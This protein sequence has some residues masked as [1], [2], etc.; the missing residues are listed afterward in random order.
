MTVA[1]RIGVMNAGK[2]VQVGPPSEVYEQPK[3]RWIADFI[4]DVNLIEGRVVSSGLGHAVIEAVAGGRMLV[5]YVGPACD[6]RDGVG[7]A[8]AG[9]IAD[10]PQRVR[11]RA[12]RTALPDASRTSAISATFRSTRSSSTA[13]TIVKATMANRDA[14]DRRDRSGGATGCGSAFQPEAGVVLDA[15]EHARSMAAGRGA[16]RLAQWLVILVPAL[17]LIVFFACAVPDRAEDQPVA[18]RD[19]AAA[20]HAAAR[21][22]RRLAGHP[23]FLCRPDVGQL[24]T[25][26]LRRD[27]S[28]VLPAQ[29]RDRCALDAAAAADRLSGRLRHRTRAAPN[30]TCSW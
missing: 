19:R 23:R 17:W 1:D 6:R 26:R 7:R 9:E 29:P 10:R 27:L 14:A 5:S 3:S 18:D 16:G 15:N 20:L 12:M 25:A 2:L 8:A 24:R 30:G 21:P 11:L 13:D 22:C 4:G 28:D